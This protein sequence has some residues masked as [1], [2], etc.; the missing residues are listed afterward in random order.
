MANSSNLRSEIQALRNQ[1]LA[2]GHE[3]TRNLETLKQNAFIER[4]ISE[5]YRHVY[6]D[7]LITFTFICVALL[8]LFVTSL[9]LSS[10]P[11]FDSLR[12]LLHITKYTF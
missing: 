7:L 4:E 2:R 5:D 12:L 9:K 8:I 1:A 3:D 10:L 6:N 11:F